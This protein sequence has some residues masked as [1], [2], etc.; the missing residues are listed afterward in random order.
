MNDPEF[1]LISLTPGALTHGGGEGEAAATPEA[2]AAEGEAS[3]G[4]T[5]MLKSYPTRMFQLTL[6]GKYATLIDFLNQLGAL[7]LKRLVTINKISLTPS[8]E[9]KG[10]GSP[11]LQIV[12]PLTAYFHGG[13][14]GAGGGGTQ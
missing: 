10:G 14:E 7:R 9:A 3:A 8:G 11:S 6:K 12:I 4:V 13:A 5:S 2:A 1:A